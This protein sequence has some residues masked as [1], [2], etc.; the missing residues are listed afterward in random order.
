MSALKIP[1]TVIIAIDRRR[2]AF[3]WTGEDSC[4][5]SKC[6]VAWDAVQAPKDKGGLGVKDLEL[7]N[8]CLLMKFI[9]KI[10]SGH[11]TCWKDWLL[12]T[13]SPFDD[14]NRSPSGY[15]WRI[16]NDE[17]NSFRSITTV[18]VK[19]GASTSF[20]FDHWLPD[21][22]LSSTHYALFS[23]TTCPNVS[24]QHVFQTDF[25]L[26]L[27]PRLT[28]LASQQLDS[29]MSI[30]QAVYLEDGDD[31]R[32]LKLSGRPYTT[33]D[34]YMALDSTG[35]VSDPHGRRI[36]RTKVPNKV[37][38]FSWLYFKDRLSTR[39]NLLSKH[40]VDG[41]LCERCLRHREDRAHVFYGCPRSADIWSS[42]GMANVRRLT[43][44]EAWRAAPPDGL[45]AAIWPFIFLSLLW[46]IW[47]GRNG[48]IFRNETFCTRL[49]LSRVCDDLVIW[50][51]RL[52][53]TLVNSLL[54]WCSHI[55]N[56]N[57]N[58]SHIPASWA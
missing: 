13:S 40:V 35:D 49:V 23:H 45:D 20:W 2:R 21:G 38:V 3:F 31:V 22:P 36:W 11:Q 50:R 10:L 8:R 28:N 18:Q 34:A 43:D 24:V 7:Q 42:I 27:R 29:L 9:N 5:G 6:L 51:K 32:V 26:R 57:S 14:H 54:S 4:H 37:K 12:S 55:R 41:D 58:S 46:R 30:L 47:D 44:E 48:H 56:C 52:P 15:L 33:R 25:E 19:N 39:V 17:L 16:I 53:P 1:K